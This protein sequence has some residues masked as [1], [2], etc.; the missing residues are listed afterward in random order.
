MAPPERNGAGGHHD[1]FLTALRKAATSAAK[2]LEPGAI[3]AAFVGIHQ[4]GGADFDDDALG[5]GQSAG[6]DF[7]VCDGHGI[8]IL[9]FT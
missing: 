3:Q 8:T 2:A 5:V 9:P 7:T 4:Q 1:D 6:G